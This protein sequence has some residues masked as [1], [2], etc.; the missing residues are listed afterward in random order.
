[1]NFVKK[2][3]ILRQVK[4]G[5][6][7]DGR[8]LSGLIKIEQYGKNVAVEVSVIN[9]APLSSGEYYCLIADEKERTEILPLRGKSLFNIISEADFSD[10]FCGV[11]CFV[12]N[13]ITPIA[14]GVNGNRTYDWRTL[15]KNTVSPTAA[16]DAA[17]TLS[18]NAE[19]EKR[20]E[21][22][23][24]TKA[25]KSKESKESG[26]EAESTEEIK[27]NSEEKDKDKESDPKEKTAVNATMG[28]V[29]EENREAKTAEKDEKETG[30]YDDETVAT[31]NYYR[32]EEENNERLGIP[33]TDRDADHSGGD[34]KQGEKERKDAAENDDFDGVRHAFKTDNERNTDDGSGEDDDGEAYYRSVKREFDELKG[35]YPNDSSL[36]GAFPYSEWV[37]IDEGERYYLVGVIFEELKAKYICYALPAKE[38]ETPPE[39][40]AKVCAFVPAT[41]FSDGN[42]FFVL[43]QSCLTGECIRP[44]T[45]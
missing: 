25:E 26:K 34:Q 17:I 45:V 13:G 5:F 40:I 31:E 12:K 29:N 22:I 42:G 11:I 36:L 1:M 27:T 28:G 44:K 30:D 38:G 20:A 8:T 23:P 15:V 33:K 41:P 39:E 7:E 32:R 14:Y 37:R 9:F 3:C 18:S 6:S 19:T 24:T 2:M 21:E 4:Q 35:K 43:F 10:G 16:S